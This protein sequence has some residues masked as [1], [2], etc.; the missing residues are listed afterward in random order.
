MDI[1]IIHK[2]DNDFIK[3]II[4]ANIKINNKYNYHIIG[5]KSISYFNDIS[6][7]NF[8]YIDNYE[9]QLTKILDK[10]Y[11][12][13]NV[14]DYNYELFCLKRFIYIYNYCKKNNITDFLYIDS[15]I[16]IYDDID[17]YFDF[18]NNYDVQL[19]SNTSTWFSYW[20]ILGLDKFIKYI[21]NIYTSEKDKYLNRFNTR[22]CDMD[23]LELAIN[24][25]ILVANF[26]KQK[27]KCFNENNLCDGSFRYYLEHNL[28][29]QN[30]EQNNSNIKI[31]DIIKFIKWKDGIPYYKNNKFEFIHFQGFTKRF[32]NIFITYY[33]SKFNN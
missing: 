22:F 24:N 18:D 4:T 1:L 27:L 5:D 16:L 9:S 6:N 11:I 12:H 3:N 30:I 25:N 14:N 28:H 21:I 19:L 10:I 2:Y 15:D 26:I 20:N 32:I 7:I 33:N 29:I 23:V 13:D 17:K 31:N 8:D